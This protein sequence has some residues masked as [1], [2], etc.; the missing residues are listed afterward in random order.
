MAQPYDCNYPFVL[1]HGDLHGRNVMVSHSS[2]RR[3]LAILDWDFGGSHALP[4]ADEAFEVSSPDTNENI[5]VR[6]K[7]GDELFNTLL[8][9][10]KLVGFLPRDDHLTGL[11]A[12]M[13]LF[14]LDCE[15]KTARGK[16][17][18]A[19][20]GADPSIDATSDIPIDAEE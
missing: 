11:V 13:K 5:D 17:V 8:Q 15:A 19:S 18:I 9:I 4:L 20:V 16:D 3:I 2:P 1:R 14:V 12:S 7:Q 6:V 10:D